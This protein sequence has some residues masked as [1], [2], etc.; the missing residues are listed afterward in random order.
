VYPTSPPLETSPAALPIRFTA[1]GRDYFR[2]WIVDLLLTITT[3]G[4][5]APFAKVRQWR[6]FHENT[7]IDGTPLSFHGDP[8]R[9]LRGYLLVVG[10]V[11]AFALLA[12]AWPLAEALPML[13]LAAV[14]PW[15]LHSALRFRLGQTSWRGRR[16]HFAGGVAGAYRVFWPV[17]LPLVFTTVGPVLLMPDAAKDASE[18][19]QIPSTLLAMGAWMGLGSLLMVGMFPWIHCRLKQYQHDHCA[20]ADECT[21]LDGVRPW[22]FYMV[23]I[24]LFGVSLVL[25]LGL[26]TIGLLTGLVLPDAL[27]L[28][29]PVLYAT[30]FAATYAYLTSR[31]QNLV[32]SHTRSAHVH[33]RSQLSA[34]AL[35]GLTLKN[36]LL[37]AVTLGLY[38]PFAVVATRRMRLAAMS[39][40]VT[41]PVEF[42]AEA[43]QDHAANGTVGEAAGGLLGIEIAL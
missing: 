2:L 5:Y 25:L 32:W 3:I 16:M 29:A 27:A 28:V 12:A 24:G 30:G 43:R 39:I 33:F 21:R 34:S 4:L 31:L 23:Q 22:D 17:A 42:F 41:C 11:V 9:M 14:G 26:G 10:S 13:A 15:L 20:L 18:L 7:L 8:W 38:W 36:S 1:S 19:Q 37:T 6:Y 35:F 40:E